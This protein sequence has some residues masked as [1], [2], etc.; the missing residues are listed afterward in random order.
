MLSRHLSSR[1]TRIAVMK[2]LLL[3]FAVVLAAAACAE[4][5]GTTLGNATPTAALG[6][7]D[8]T[9]LPTVGFYQPP[10]AQPVPE[11]EA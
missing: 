3:L 1:H 5:D 9:P 11:D 8:T 4:E 10:N 7:A 2:V 6:S